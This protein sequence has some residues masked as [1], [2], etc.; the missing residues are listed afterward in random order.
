MKTQNPYLASLPLAHPEPTGSP[1]SSGRVFYM[2][3]VW[4]DVVGYEGRYMVSSHG[5]VK[6][7]NYLGKKGFAKNLKPMVNESG[8]LRVEIGGVTTFIHKLVMLAFGEDT[9]RKETINHKDGVKTNN[10]ADNLEWA[11]R[12]E[13][14]RHAYDVL[15][16]R[17]SRT[18]K[19]GADCKGS[20]KILQYSIKGDFIKEWA[21]QSEVQREIGIND[22]NIS[23]CC[24][25]RYKSAGG[26]VW[27]FK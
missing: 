1:L 7:L 18:G 16:R 11:T 24:H 21:S 2:E 12:S 3:E 19:F 27:K 23:S 13:N 4:K 25:G 6:S 8:Y 20:K 5:N 10:Y 17:G 22:G 26:Y 14:I 15:H 9:I